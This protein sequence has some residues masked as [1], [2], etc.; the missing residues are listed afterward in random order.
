MSINRILSWFPSAWRAR[1]ETEVRDLLAAHPVTWR[2]RVDLAAGCVDAWLQAL[3]GLASRPLSRPIHVG[4]RISALLLIGGSGA[5]ASDVLSPAMEAAA[6]WTSAVGVAANLAGLVT[7]LVA[8]LFFIRPFIDEPAQRPGLLPS[9]SLLS[10][11][12]LALA[13]DGSSM[14]LGDIVGFGMIATMRYS[15]FHLDGDRSSLAAP[16]S[17][18]GLRHPE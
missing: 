18:L 13:L 4:L 14:S 8:V 11:F 2:T 1:Y 15:W 16:R 5:I 6:W 9:L 3:A 12:F 7:L 10:V 17:I